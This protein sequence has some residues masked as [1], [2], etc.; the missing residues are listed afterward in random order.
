[1][2]QQQST[3]TGLIILLLSAMVAHAIGETPKKP[4]SSAELITLGFGDFSSSQNPVNKPEVVP[5]DSASLPIRQADIKKE[6][7]IVSQVL[8]GDTFRIK[9][10]EGEFQLIGTDAPEII[11]RLCFGEEAKAFTKGEIEGREVQL[12]GPFKQDEYG[13][14]LVYVW[15]KRGGKEV[16]L[17]EELIKEG[18]GKVNP[19][20]HF[21][22]VMDYV[23]LQSKARE[24]KKGF[25]IKCVQWISPS[26]VFDGFKPFGCGSHLYEIENAPDILIRNNPIG[27]GGARTIGDK[28]HNYKSSYGY[29]PNRIY[30]DQTVIDEDGFVLHTKEG[31]FGPGLKLSEVQRIMSLHPRIAVQDFV[32][33]GGRNMGIA[34]VYPGF[35]SEIG[36][37]ESILVP[38]Q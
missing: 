28:I 19:G 7:V 14:L 29:I 31:E 38:V 10:F 32:A 9:G 24:E 17:N 18:F 20:F 15:F 23:V 33:P 4:A 34:R 27:N 2:A 26:K 6:S 16:C 5:S 8:N 1:M 22:E 21:P 11:N 35:G 12:K 30:C 36:L 13:R 25:W 3:R 37:W